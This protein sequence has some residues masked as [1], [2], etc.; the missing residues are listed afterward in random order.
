[1]RKVVAA[2]MA[3]ALTFLVLIAV[4]IA[5]GHASTT[6]PR[7]NAIGAPNQMYNP[8]SYLI[9]LP[10]DGQILEGKYTNIRFAPYA[11]PNLYDETLLFCG[12]VTGMFDG[13]QGVV[14]ITYR[15]QASRAYRGIGC[16]EL[17]SIFQIETKEGK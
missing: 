16:H 17:L 2:L 4:L 5:T 3:L 12:D 15:T 14:A 7:P 13:K 6:Q 9:A 1:M 10:I 11:A 8:F